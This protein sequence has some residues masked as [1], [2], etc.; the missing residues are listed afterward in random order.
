MMIRKIYTAF[1][2]GMLISL[3]GKAQSLEDYI[4]MAYKNTAEIKASRYGVEAIRSMEQ[5]ARSLPDTRITGGMF[6]LQPET[7]VGAQTF[8]AGI[9]QEFPWF[10]TRKARETWYREK[11]REKAFDTILVRKELAYRIK[12]LYYEM[13]EKNRAIGIL[14]DTRKILQS[15]EDMAM[16]ALENNRATMNDVIK[17][18]IQK[19]QLH[20]RIYQYFNDL[21]NLQRAFNRLLERPPDAPVNLPANLD[22]NTIFVPEPNPGQHPLARRKLQH[23][24][25]L[26]RREKAVRREAKPRWIIGTNYIAVE[27]RQGITLPQNGKDILL[28][29]IGLKIPLFNKNY[30]ARLQQIRLEKQETEMLYQTTLKKLLDEWDAANTLLENQL[31]LV[32]AAQKN[33]RETQRAINISLKAYETGM[34]DYDNILR[35]QMQK[36]DFQLKELQAVKRSFTAKAK[37]EYLLP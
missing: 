7:R 16:A 20:A 30:S 8:S 21:E 15:Y 12:V 6:L 26:D 11:T 36:L 9:T 19:N 5:S 34:L 27:N 22:V 25:V 33:A 2:F 14:K 31:V 24:K 10:G 17:I 1:L 4:R 13:Y 35:L 28:A 23:Q 18:R 3:T 37:L 29:Q 32:M